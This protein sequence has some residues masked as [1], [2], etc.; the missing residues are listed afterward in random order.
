[1]R[2]VFYSATT[3]DG[4]IADEHDSLDWLFVRDRDESGPLNYG[5]FIKDVGA[6][7]MGATTYQW[8]L[9]H[10]ARTGE[11]WAY[12][13]PS[14]VCSPTVSSR[15]TKASPSPRTTCRTSTRRW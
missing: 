1:M 3:L 10:N 9:D 8:V 15:R 4:F 11:E 6:I 14:W 12:E 13:Q 2:T 7:C 5:D